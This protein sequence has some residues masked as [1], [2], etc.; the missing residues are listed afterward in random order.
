MKQVIMRMEIDILFKEPVATDDF[1]CDIGG[2][3][4]NIDGKSIPFDFAASSGDFTQDGNVITIDFESGCGPFFNE[5]DIEECF[6]ESYEE[7]G[8]K[9]SDITAEFL[10]RVEGIEEIYL[11]P[12]VVDDNEDEGIRELETGEYD[13]VIKGICFLDENSKEYLIK[14]EVIDAYAL[15]LKKIWAEEAVKKQEAQ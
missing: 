13:I 15:Y 12:M 7:L 9:S 2:Y 3:T 11:C 1:S 8:L 14:Q 10:S 4:F 6:E 5:Y